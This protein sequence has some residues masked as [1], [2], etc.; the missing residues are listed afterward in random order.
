MKKRLSALTALL[1]A[2]CLLLSGCSLI[3]DMDAILERW[4]AAKQ[5][6]LENGGSDPEQTHSLT[7][8]EQQYG[9]PIYDPDGLLSGEEGKINRDV[10]TEAL[11]T[12]S[13]PLIRG[14]LQNLQRRE[15]SFEMIFLD[16]ESDNLAQTEYS[17]SMIRIRVYAPREFFDSEADDGI[18]LQTITHEFGHVFHDVLESEYGPD[19]FREAWS[20]LNG[21]HNYGDEW[22][23]D[24]GH[25]FAYDYGLTEYYEDVATVFEN[26][27]AY[28]LIASSRFTREENTPLYLKAKLLYTLM[29]DF[30]DLSGS[31]LF[32]GFL[33]AMDHRDD[34][35]SLLED[36]VGL[37]YPGDLSFLPSSA[38]AA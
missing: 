20:F 4:E 5:D 36:L 18:T 16:E 6:V 35:A 25:Y 3:P 33:T 37:G 27:G 13:V 30:F 21:E 9:F 23:K 12:L 22:S 8:L 19:A 34:T 32:D 26:L 1:C 38:L 28:P 17:H 11:D 31:A 10:L 7:D 29:D 2:L 14:M 24:C 15:I